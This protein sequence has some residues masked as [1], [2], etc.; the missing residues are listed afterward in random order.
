MLALERQRDYTLNYTHTNIRKFPCHRG[1]EENENHTQTYLL[2]L[3][4]YSLCYRYYSGIP[5]KL[6]CRNCRLS[7]E[8]SPERI[9]AVIIFK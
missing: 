4:K 3:M 7:Q 2:V 8:I 9:H 5:L 1:P 6:R